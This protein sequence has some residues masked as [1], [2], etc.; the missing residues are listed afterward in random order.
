MTLPS[1]GQRRSTGPRPL[2]SIGVPV[3]NGV[4]Y[5]QEAL[6]S[7]RAQTY[8]AIEIVIS[9]N[10]STDGTEA[11]CRA[12]AAEDPRIRYHRSERNRGLVWNHRNALA[13]A[14]GEYFM[15]APYDDHFAPTYVER[16][17]NLFDREPCHAYVFA[18]TVLID[19]KGE[20]IGRELARQRLTD[21]SPSARFW[22][23]LVVQGGINFYGLARRD[24]WNRIG[25][26]VAVPRAERI[27]LTELALHGTFGILPADLYFRRIHDG[28]ITA[29]RRDRRKEAMVLD[30]DRPKGPRST[31]AIIVAEYFLGYVAA[32]LRAPLPIPERIRTLRALLRWFL[33][34]VPGLGVR[35]VRTKALAIESSGA[36]S[37]PEG[38]IG[39][40]Y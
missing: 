36:G 37:L 11:L 18:E 6:D 5:L 21:P 35:D 28:Q 19:A 39:I 24:M 16:G 31:V 29:L 12:L 10:A 25:A 1:S 20:R 15:F 38:R 40:G 34:A 23:V 17:I 8:E 26:Y 33:R 27:M 30:P 3:Y 14:R 32:I 9:D 13:L 7:L 2:V 22:D 4:P